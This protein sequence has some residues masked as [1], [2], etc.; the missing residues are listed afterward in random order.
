[1][2]WSEKINQLKQRNEQNVDQLV[3]HQQLIQDHD[4][5]LV[6]PFHGAG[7]MIRESGKI[8]AFADYGLGF[9]MDPK[10][11]TMTFFAPKMIFVAHEEQHLSDQQQ[12][13][14]IYDEW[15]MALLELEEKR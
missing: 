7:M 10:T 9:Q 15:K 4:C 12:Q 11:K 6:H 5:G 2:H 1:M 14:S 3:N 8:E 13:G